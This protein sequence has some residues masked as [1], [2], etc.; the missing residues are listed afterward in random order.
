[1]LYHLIRATVFLLGT[2]PWPISQSIGR[3][4]GGLV[5]VIPIQRFAI[6]TDNIQK[7]LGVERSEAKRINRHVLK[8]FGQMLFEIPHVVKLKPDELPRYGTFINEEHLLQAMAKDKGIFFLTGHFGNW[9]L[10]CI[11]VAITFKSLAVVARP[12]DNEPLDRFIDGLRSRFGTE[13]IPKQ[14][15]MRKILEAL[16]KNKLIAILLDQNVDWY[17]GVFVNFLGEWACTNKGLALMAL[18]TGTPVVPAFSVRQPDGRYH[19]IF[20]PEVALIRTGDKTRDVEDNTILFT[21]IIER[22]VREH[23]DQW[24][25]YHKRWKTRP[26]WPLPEDFYD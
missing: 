14:R 22:Y 24:F 3:L 18:K 17:E 12:L 25:W 16:R 21:S 23:P 15:G 19:L 11:A 4:L 13:I 2:I 6:S 1:M 9:E 5:S 7:A 10:M 20:E 8:H 26:Y